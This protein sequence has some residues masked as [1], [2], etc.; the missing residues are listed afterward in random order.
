MFLK[1]REIYFSGAKVPH[2]APETLVADPWFR[3]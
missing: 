1:S 2:A 3:P